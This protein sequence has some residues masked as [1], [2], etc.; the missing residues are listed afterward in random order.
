VNITDICLRR[1]VFAWMLMFGTILFGIIAISRIGVSQFPDVNNPT[2]TVSVSWPGASPED[3]ETGIVNPI[4]DVLAQVGGVLEITS[5]A[6][7]NSARVTATFDIDR[8]ID[9]AVQDVQAKVA[10]IQRQLP[11]GVQPPTVSK[12]NP[13]DTP[14]ITVG[15]SGPFARQLLADVAR[16]QLQDALQTLDG[17]GQV[18]MMGYLDRAVRIWIDA[19]KLVATGTTVSDITSALQKQHV[20]SS[21]GQLTNGQRAIDIRVLGEAADLQTLRDIVIKK[22]AAPIRLGDVALIQDGFVDVTSVARSNGTP[23]QAMG[24]LKQPGSNAV[25]VADAVRAAIA[26]AQKTLPPGMTV[27]VLFDTTGFITESVDEI[28]LELGLAVILTALVCWLFLGSLSSTL[29]VLFAIPMSLLGTIAV[30]YFLHWTLNTFT[31][32]GLSLAVGLVVDDAVMVMENIFRHAE[33]GKDRMRASSEGTKEI[34]FAALAATIAVIAIFLPVAFMTGVIGKYFLQ[35]GVTLSVAVGIS[36]FEAIT[37]APARC[38]QMLNVSQH[39]RSW[40]GR[41]GDRA[42]AALARVYGRALAA[43]LRWPAAVLGGGIIVTLGAGW[44][45]CQLKQEMVPSQDQSRLQVRLTTAVGADLD[46]TDRLTQKAEAMLGKH[47][48]ITRV[49]TT[50]SIGSASL[51]LT[52]VDPKA[53]SVTQA[54]LSA[55]IRR[56]LGQIPGLRVAVQDLSQQGFAGG[57]GKPVELTVRGGDWTTLVG[58]S[59]QVRGELEQSGLAVDL[60]SDYSLGPPELAVSPD[61]PRASDVNVNVTDIA[62]TVNALIG[63]SVVGQYSTAGRRMDIRMRLLKAQRTRPEDLEL[64]RVRSTTGNLVPLSSVTTTSEQPALQEINHDNR[65][66]AIRITGNVAPG[67]SQSEVLGFIDSLSPPPGY[68]FVLSGQ[69]SQFGDAM[70]SLLFALLVGIIIAYMVLASQFNSLLHPITVLTILPL[71]L[72]G[73]MVALWITGKTLNVFSMIGLLLLM[74]IVKKNSIILVDY[75]NEVRA[76]EA[77]DAAEAMRRAGP[78]RLR[79]ILMT[80]VATMMAAVPSALGLGPGAETRGPMADAIIGGLILS[81]VLSLFVVPAFYVLSDRGKRLLTRRAPVAP[82]APA[83]PVTPPPPEADIA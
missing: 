65:Q 34:T 39:D 38:A 4:E 12:S 27:E 58:L 57:R 83:V 41:V 43:L 42:F 50:V 22:V 76:H 80:A 72:A 1:P 33:M 2:V 63:G 53:R 60:D 14:I 69:S 74:G 13:D 78:V 70:H 75:A 9:L 35:F 11:S 21:G 36:Y 8:N 6:K 48:E 30:L 67:H 16:Y 49:L 52:M 20:T 64:L 61:R 45:A 10:Q 44:S 29:N 47:K 26:E 71:S 77:L 37:L 59:Q 31:L 46:E 28:K 73:A 56:E 62:T 7:H 81:T 51:S 40:L 17:V 18:Q 79:P 68:S 24:I 55:T 15:V 82:V 25:A 23:V 3:V 54:Q 19:D 66:R 5:Q 32:L